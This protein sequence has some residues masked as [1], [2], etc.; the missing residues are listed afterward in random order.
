MLLFIQKLINKY[1]REFVLYFTFGLI[2]TGID[3][4]TL[5]GLQLWSTLNY[6][7]CAG[8]AFIVGNIASYIFSVKIVFIKYKRRQPV[9]E[10]LIFVGINLIG[11]LINEIIISSFSEAFLPISK[12][13][14]IIVTS[15]WNFLAK[16]LILFNKPK[17]IQQNSP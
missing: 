2:A 14:A 10:F 7:I 8:I 13:L 11:L 4:V 16:K 5:A 9:A 17:I 12:A 6:I 15:C 3:V 1:G